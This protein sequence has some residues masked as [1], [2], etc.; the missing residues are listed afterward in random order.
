MLTSY[1]AVARGEAPVKH[2]RRLGRGQLQ[3]DGYRALASWSGTMFE[4]LMPALFLPFER[5]S[6]LY[7]S[8][9][10]CL[11]V[12]RRSV[13]PGQPWGIS[14][15]AYFALDADRNY[16][17]KAHGCPELALRRSA[18]RETVVA[19]YASFLALAVSPR[20]AVQNL[21]RLA[22]RGLC[23][24]WGF[25]EALDLTPGRC[26]GAG[27]EIVDCTMAHHAGMSL[28]AAANALC[29]DVVRR[30]FFEDAAN[31]A[32]ELLLQEQP[33]D[34]A[35]L[36]RRRETEPG[37]RD[38]RAESA[39]WLRRGACG[40]RGMCLLSNGMYRL[41]LDERGAGGAAA[42]GLLP[43]DGPLRLD[44]DGEALLPG[45]CESWCFR[46]DGASWS[47]CRQE[48]S[49]GAEAFVSP[50]GPGECRALRLKSPRNR[51]VRLTLSLRPVLARQADWESHPSFWRLGLWAE[52]REGALLI[53]RL[54]RGETPGCWLCLRATLPL[55]CSADENGGLGWLARP[56]IRAEAELLLPADEKTELRFALALAPTADGA[57]AAAGRLL[58]AGE[59]ERGRMIG[60]AATLLGLS[61]AEIGRAMELLPALTRPR[62]YEAAP[63]K[64]LWP[65]GLSGDLPILCCRA[66]AREAE[67]LL[68]RFLLL[69]AAGLEADLVYLSDEEGEYRQPFRRSVTQALARRGLE[70]LLDARGGVHLLPLAAA[71]DAESRAAVLCGGDGKLPP[72]LETPVLSAPREAGT[73][74]P[75]GWGE[76]DFHFEAGA[77]L[78]SRPWQLPLT[79]GRFGFLAVDC[80]SGFLWLEN[81]REMPLTA[82]PALP[83]DVTGGEALWVEWEGRPVSLFAANDGLACTVRYSPGLAV[84][85]KR[86]GPRRVKTSAFI[87]R[88]TDAR[89]LLV[90]GAEDMTLCWAQRFARPDS[91]R[92]RREGALLR[93][94][95]PD[96][97]LPDRPYRVGA[98]A[99]AELE[100]GFAPAAFRMRLRPPH[101]AV[102]ACGCCEKA[103]LEALLDPS[104]ALAELCLTTRAWAKRCAAIPAGDPAAAHYLGG[105]AVWQ[106]L[107]CRLLA[108]C[109]L[110][111]QGGAYGFRDQLQDAANLLPFER[112]PLRE[113]LL[114]AARHQYRE[115]DVMHWW[116][117]HPSGD[118]G[119]R[120]RCADDLL[121]LPWALCEWFEATGDADFCRRAEPF[122]SSRPLRPDERDRYE[123]PPVSGE[124]ASLT[125]HA[126]RAL[127]CCAARGFGRHGLPRMG[128]G[129]W[130]DGFDRAGGESVWLGFFL[131]H[132]AAR[133]AGLLDALGETGAESWRSFAAKVGRAA[134]AAYA[135]GHWLRG[136]WPDGTPLGGETRVD[137]TVQSWAVLSGFGSPEKTAS[138]LDQAER[139][140]VD[141]GHGLV[142]LF[143][144]PFAPDERS[145][146]YLTGYGEGFRENG[147]Q[148]THGA[149]WLALAMHRAGR[150]ETAREILRLL[151]P[152]T[153]DPVRYGGEPFVLPADVCAAPGREGGAGWTWYTGS[154]GWF[155]RAAREIGL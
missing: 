49:F 92:L 143:D 66:G 107:A 1:L 6:L 137:A 88:G 9:R 13:P 14:E 100:T 105:W 70:P 81:A 133:F 53:R 12:Q 122:L 56:M 83:E 67:S 58:E 146:G 71:K 47:G 57:F 130:N 27:G 134:D 64:A 93:A 11:Y 97:W 94:D 124:K 76:R 115:G 4:Y 60:G 138:A 154:A 135:D 95:D 111:Q 125:E 126:R 36:I 139:R 45:E 63:K 3:K 46:E 112:G 75:F 38:T 69:R 147:G 77:S 82:P 142:R 31:R 39:P 54:P 129:D 30:R 25:K 144:P 5:G 10:C 128:G 106:T 41:T 59:N 68:G 153:R 20:A 101:L 78:P 120:S 150:T 110:Y 132:V 87:P 140:L 19:P 37:L 127:E 116:H 98:G 79:N 99:E 35:V 24:R 7:E 29:G 72:P 34:G 152:E 22:R 91:L 119:L 141:R 80:G 32:H 84:W 26:R 155:L 109:S 48:L 73:V 18:E 42:D 145:P 114:D 136:F 8:S 74:P 40:E 21:R 43:Y 55:R 2:W 16:R 86:L 51:S 149:V 23:G 33:G 103:A 108:R 118:R 62:L 44:L 121:W 102:L 28:L 123:T 104:A 50:D 65:H 52:M 89:V 131:A 113:R 17:Y 117:P 148:Y 85:E 90:E 61:A 96:A 151:L 15:S